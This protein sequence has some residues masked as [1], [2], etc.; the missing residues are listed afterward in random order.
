MAIT[1][2]STATASG[3]ANIAF[4]LGSAVEYIFEFFSIHPADS[5]IE[6]EVQFNA[7]DSSSFDEKIVSGTKMALSSHANST[8]A[9]VSDFSSFGMDD[10]TGAVCLARFVGNAAYS[11][12][13][14][15]LR[16]FNPSSTTFM[17]MFES[18]MV[19]SYKGALDATAAGTELFEHQGYINTT[20]AVDEI[21]FKFASGN[22]D[23]GVIKM[24]K[25][26]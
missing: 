13:S 11:S 10:E 24:Y 12:V 22:I 21:Q 3:T 9:Y 5:D 1:L 15:R 6:F 8:E 26:S 14:G 25:V 4:D 18:S 20:T 19:N 23:A 2:V 7:S 16:I 17:N